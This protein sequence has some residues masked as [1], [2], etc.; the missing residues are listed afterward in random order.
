MVAVEIF[1]VIPHG[2]NPADAS[3]SGDKEPREIELMWKKSG[4]G[5]V[6]IEVMIIMPFP[7]DVTRP[8]LIDGKIFPIE[9]GSLDR[10]SVV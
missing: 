10:K 9:I 6:R 2:F 7:G 1:S 4:A 3:V 8:N 5:A